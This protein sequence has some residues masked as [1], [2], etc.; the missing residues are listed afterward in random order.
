MRKIVLHTEA[1]PTPLFRRLVRAVREVGI[2]RLAESYKTNFWFA[3]DAK[4]RNIVEEVIPSTV[5]SGLRNTV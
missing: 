2:E 1:L 4:P 3:L 5:P